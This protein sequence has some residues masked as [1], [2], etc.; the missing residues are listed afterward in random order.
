MI[1]LGLRGRITVANKVS[2]TC[3]HPYPHARV[4]PTFPPNIP[5]S[6]QDTDLGLLC[7]R[8]APLDRKPI[9][10][11]ASTHLF[12]SPLWFPP[13]APRRTNLSRSMRYKVTTMLTMSPGRLPVKKWLSQLAQHGGPYRSEPRR[14][15]RPSRYS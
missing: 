9:D 13:S 12:T 15:E 2:V 6:S 10:E 1:S 8:T 11:I 14:A 5:L 3:W 7:P 4:L